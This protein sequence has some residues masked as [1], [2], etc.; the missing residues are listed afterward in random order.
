MIDAQSF[1]S[2]LNQGHEPRPI[3]A[4]VVECGS[5]LPLLVP[6]PIPCYHPNDILITNNQTVVFPPASHPGI[7][8]PIRGAN[9]ALKIKILSQN[10]RKT[11]QPNIGKYSH[12]ETPGGRAVIIRLIHGPIASKPPIFN[13][14]GPHSTFQKVANL[15]PKTMPF[16]NHFPK[17]KLLNNC[18]SL[19]GLRT[20]DCGLWTVNLPPL[21][22]LS[23]A[24]ALRS[25]RAEMGSAIPNP[26][27]AM[28][29]CQGDACAPHPCRPFGTY[30]R[31]W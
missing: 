3:R 31:L 29:C 17:C 23:P 15:P 25:F 2:S 14:Y 11:I 1:G 21:N 26:Q 18:Q 13:R 27:S 24:P 12:F 4:C 9:P 10:A 22:P 6:Q 30:S 28:E 16:M 19:P 5:P 20:A 7:F 8:V